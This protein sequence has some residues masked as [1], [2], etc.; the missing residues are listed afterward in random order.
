MHAHPAITLVLILVGSGVLPAIGFFVAADRAIG[1]SRLPHGKPEDVGH[2]PDD[3][4]PAGQVGLQRPA[5]HPAVE[6][7]RP[8]MTADQ[9]DLAR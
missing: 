3:H 5:E 7:E 6:V 2:E 8:G 4:R 9:D 1:R